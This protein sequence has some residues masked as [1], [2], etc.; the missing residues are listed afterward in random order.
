M[1]ENIKEKKKKGVLRENIEAIVFAL[2]LALI[3]RAFVVQA[4]K[5]PSGSMLDTLFIGDHILVNKFVYG[6]RMPFTNKTIFPVSKPKRG[7]IVVF[8]APVD[9][10]K[11]FIKRV[12]GLP[13]EKI[14]LRNKQLY[15]N[16]KKYTDEAY[17]KNEDSKIYKGFFNPR[18]NFGP[19]TVPENSYFMMGDNR[20]NSTDSRFLGSIEYE[21]LKGQAFIIYWSWKKEDFGVRWSRLGKILR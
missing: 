2:I 20:D 1:N 9:P 12:I 17:A 4:Y 21:R 13:G 6:V 11:D 19:I 8:K 15:I 10:P 18:D 3:I 16:N 7:D 5:I 14:E